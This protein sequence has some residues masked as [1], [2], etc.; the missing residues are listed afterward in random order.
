MQ[1][2]GEPGSDT[3]ILQR[4]NVLVSHEAHSNMLSV[5]LASAELLCTLIC[6]C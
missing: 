5:L 1:V 6:F 4:T 3:A 2:I